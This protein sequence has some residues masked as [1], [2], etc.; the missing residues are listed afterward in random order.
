MMGL[1]ESTHKLYACGVR[2]FTRICSAAG[3]AAVPASEETLCHFAATLAGEGLRHRTI[4]SY[5]AGIRHLHISEGYGDPFSPGLHRLHY[6]LRGVKRAEG[7]AGVT[8]RERRPV[9][10]DLLRKIKGVWDPRAGEVDVVMLWA[11][12]CLAYFGFM[13]IGELTV[14]SDG[15][16][17]A[18]A[19]LLWGD[20]MVDD[21]AC[22]SR[23]E[24][25]IKASKTDPFRQG[26]S[27]FIGKVASDL[28]PVSAMLAYLV[29]R[30]SHAGPL[31][32][33]SDGR[34]LTRQRL[35]TAVKEALD[36][37]GV[38]SGQYS[39]HSFRIGAATTAAARGLEDSTVRTLG[40]WKSLAYLEYIR[41]PR[42][43][44]ANYTSRLC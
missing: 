25:R 8:K 1:A 5:M 16:Y 39:G 41:I 29:V 33:F 6:V 4:K 32:K 35:V 40:R 19:H 43:Q 7:M 24:V 44:L 13:R 15:A 28:C 38:E 36:A 11:A 10:P 30:G 14:P 22:P 26:I 34:S 27:L 17:D 42:A 23:M 3:L 20:I 31:F 12:C 9:T 21:P 2:R 18:S 37:A